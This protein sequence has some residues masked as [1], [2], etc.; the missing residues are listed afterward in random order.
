[1]LTCKQASHLASKAMDGKLTWREWLGLR[2]HIALCRL[3]RRYVSDIK[4][5]RTVMRLAGKSDQTLLPESVKLSRQSRE[6]IQKVLHKA[7]PPSE[8]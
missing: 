5:L 1:M 3:C 6:R 2:L 8:Q 4:R 7:L